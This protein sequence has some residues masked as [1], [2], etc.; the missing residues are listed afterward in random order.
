MCNV[1]H[2]KLFYGIRKDNITQFFTPKKSALYSKDLHGRVNLQPCYAIRV[3]SLQNRHRLP[4]CTHPILCT[5]KLAHIPDDDKIHA[6][7]KR[8]FVQ[9]RVVIVADL[10]VQGVSQDAFVGGEHAEVVEESVYDAVSALRGVPEPTGQ[11]GDFV[12]I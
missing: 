2:V 9:D 3:S 11:G 5:L 1:T 7:V 12:S 10:G 8:Q 4:N 6:L